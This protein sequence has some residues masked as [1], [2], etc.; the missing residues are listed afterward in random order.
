[1]IYC[2]VP[3]RKK[4]HA[5]TQNRPFRVRVLHR[6]FFASEIFS[7]NFFPCTVCP[8]KFYES[9]AVRRIFGTQLRE[10]VLD[11]SASNFGYAIRSPKSRQ[12][13]AR[14]KECKTESDRIIENLICET[15]PIPRMR[16][17]RKKHAFL[18]TISYAISSRL[19]HSRCT[20]AVAHT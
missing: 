3:P 15:A 20:T 19:L 17:A 8:T 5:A 16:P 12:T 14:E 1:M 9:A 2:S 11:S 7:S 4:R 6:K 10:F 13:G 18:L